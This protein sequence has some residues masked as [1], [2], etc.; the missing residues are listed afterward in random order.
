[1][2]AVRENAEW[3]DFQ[4]RARGVPTG[5]TGDPDG[6]A[7]VIAHR[8]GDV[9]GLSN[10]VTSDRY[11]WPEA[12]AAVSPAFPGRTVV[13]YE[14]PEDL[15]PAIAAGFVTTGLLRVWLKP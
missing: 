1:M 15:P 2:D 5:L 6:A 12:L 9:V 10:L 13:G 14:R 3:C 7:R 8:S 11:G 4:V